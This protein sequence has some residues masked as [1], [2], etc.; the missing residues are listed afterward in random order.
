MVGIAN[1]NFNNS[2]LLATDLN[3][4]A[5][6]FTN[7]NVAAQVAGTKVLINKNI[8]SNPNFNNG[9]KIG[10]ILLANYFTLINN[11]I[12][13]CHVGA[14]IQTNGMAHSLIKENAFSNINLMGVWSIGNNAAALVVCN[15]FDFYRV[16]LLTMDASNPYNQAGLFTDQVICTPAEKIP[17]DN[18]FSNKLPG[19]ASDVVNL[20]PVDSFYYYYRDMAG[21]IATSTPPETAKECD[22]NNMPTPKQNCKSIT[23]LISTTEL[24]NM[25]D[26]SKKN[27]QMLLQ[28]QYLLKQQHDTLAA[29][30]LL[31]KINNTEANRLL[32]SYYIAKKI[33]LAAQHTINQ[34]P[35]TPLDNILF[36]DLY[37]LK[38]NLAASN[39]SIFDIT[40]SEESTLNNIANQYTQTSYEAQAILSLI[41]QQEYPLILPPIPNF[42]QPYYSNTLPAIHFKTN[43][44]NINIYPNPAQNTCNVQWLCNNPYATATLYLYNMQGILIKTGSIQAGNTILNISQI[45][46]GLYYYKIEYEQ[47]II[48]QNKLVI[49]K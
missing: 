9:F 41:R 26:G 16:A 11:S 5:N 38:L 8:I 13:K 3:I 18:T 45:P 6:T 28:V 33:Y 47:A 40:N 15:S 44:P 25:L 35:N 23:A 46:N 29:V 24:L 36:K 42:L 7:L 43:M 22:G 10:F 14:I 20:M 34:I 12:D 19:N 4:T 37:Q 48:Q 30:K 17:A 49:I 1:T 39:R 31:S 2:A 27:M 32:V 21:F